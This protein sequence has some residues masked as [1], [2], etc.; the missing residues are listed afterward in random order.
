MIWQYVG[1]IVTPTSLNL[2]KVKSVDIELSSMQIMTISLF[3][4]AEKELTHPSVF[5]S[6][7]V[8][9]QRLGLARLT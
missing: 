5:G 6:G 8:H 2:S 1:E 4:A 3:A 7:Y 9:R